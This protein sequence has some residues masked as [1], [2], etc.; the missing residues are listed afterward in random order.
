MMM[1]R[2]V[3]VVMVL[4]VMMVVVM[5]LMMV[6]MVMVIMIVMIVV[7]MV[8]VVVMRSMMF[9]TYRAWTLVQ[10]LFQALD[11]DY[12]VI[13]PHKFT[14][15]GLLIIFLFQ[16]KNQGLRDEDTCPG[17]MTSRWHQSGQNQ[18]VTLSHLS[19]SSP[20]KGGN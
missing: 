2:M 20:E 15:L 6:L 16:M 14:R 5:G 9:N 7:V 11:L 8:V 12:L 3:L 10:S 17:H 13:S 1:I 18:E 4:M 19:C